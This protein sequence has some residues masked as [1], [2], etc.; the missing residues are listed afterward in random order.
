MP[1][2]NDE[3]VSNTVIDRRG[4]TRHRHDHGKS[5]TTASLHISMLSTN[6]QQRILRSEAH[7]R[8][9]IRL[10]QVRRQHAREAKRI[11]ERVR[12]AIKLD[13]KVSNRREEETKYDNK[14][15]TSIVRVSHFWRSKVPV[16]V[17]C[18]LKCRKRVV[19]VFKNRKLVRK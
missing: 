3:N 18:E 10:D 15:S 11:R 5:A 17:M 16:V 6:E 8:R 2:N 9:L 4:W 12:T 1:N 7:R 13:K 14:Q 19:V